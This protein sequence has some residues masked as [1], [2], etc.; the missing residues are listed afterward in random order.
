MVFFSN[1]CGYDVKLDKPS[2]TKIFLKFYQEAKCKFCQCRDVNINMHVPMSTFFTLF[3]ITY[4]SA[5][6]YAINLTWRLLN[7][8]L[9]YLT[10]SAGVKVSLVH[11]ICLDCSSFKWELSVKHD[12]HLLLNFFIQ[13]TGHRVIDPQ[14]DLFLLVLQ[15]VDILFKKNI[16]NM[17][18]VVVSLVTNVHDSWIQE[19]GYL[20]SIQ[21]HGTWFIE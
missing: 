10:V 12:K 20:T 6:Q 21:K 18:I 7:F 16:Y 19:N 13:C 3:Y 2:V 5:W 15:I 17:P 14:P 11:L 4:Q 8:A 1:L 9:N